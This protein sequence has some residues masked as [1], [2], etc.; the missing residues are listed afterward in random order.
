MKVN[1]IEVDITDVIIDLG[2]KLYLK[3]TALIYA[4]GEPFYIAL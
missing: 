1:V 4:I 2:S 3:L